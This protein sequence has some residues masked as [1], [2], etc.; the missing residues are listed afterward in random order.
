MSH[1]SGPFKSI[2]R[3]IFFDKIQNIPEYVE[4]LSIY[5]LSIISAETSLGL[6]NKTLYAKT[7]GYVGSHIESEHWGA[8]AVEGQLVYRVSFRTA[9][10]P[11]EFLSQQANK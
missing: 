10:L 4:L 1:L 5:N 8:E 9:R 7:A 3:I 11:R 2:L 6:H